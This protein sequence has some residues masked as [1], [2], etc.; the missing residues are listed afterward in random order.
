M[1]DRS[2]GRSFIYQSDTMIVIMF[3]D[4]FVLLPIST[5]RQLQ[6]ICATLSALTRFLKS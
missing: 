4:I 6:M 3:N 1:C 2:G 5:K